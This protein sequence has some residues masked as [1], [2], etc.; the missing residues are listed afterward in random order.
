MTII[1]I[2]IYYYDYYCDY[3]ILYIIYYYYYLLLLLLLYQPYWVWYLRA[4]F[5]PRGLAAAV[6]L[7]SSGAPPPRGSAAEPTRGRLEGLGAEDL[8]TEVPLRALN[9]MRKTGKNWEKP[10]DLEPMGQFCSDFWGI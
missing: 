4:C 9:W 7:G 10:M 6:V 1:V 2:I 3:Y 5:F 8:G